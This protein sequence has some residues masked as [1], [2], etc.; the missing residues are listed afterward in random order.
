MYILRLPG[1]AMRSS[2]DGRAELLTLS[3]SLVNF[4]SR[5]EN[6]SRDTLNIIFL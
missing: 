4:H 1:T 3:S 2:G 6:T 5:K